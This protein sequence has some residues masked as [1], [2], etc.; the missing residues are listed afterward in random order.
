[1]FKYVV[2]WLRNKNIT[3]YFEDHPAARD[4]IVTSVQEV[5]PPKPLPTPAATP[6]NTDTPGEQAP[7]PLS[8][9]HIA[10]EEP[11][12]G[13]QAPAQLPSQHVVQKEELELVDPTDLHE[14]LPGD[15]HDQNSP[16]TQQELENGSQPSNYTSLEDAD[17]SEGKQATG[18]S[19]YSANLDVSAPGDHGDNFSDQDA[20]PSGESA[21]PSAPPS[22]Q[23]QSDTTRYQPRKRKN[24]FDGSRGSK[25]THFEAADSTEV[26]LGSRSRQCSGPFELRPGPDQDE[27]HDQQPETSNVTQDGRLAAATP[28]AAPQTVVIRSRRLS[29]EPPGGERSSIHPQTEGSVNYGITVQA[30][31]IFQS[32]L[33]S[34][35]LNLSRNFSFHTLSRSRIGRTKT[36]PG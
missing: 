15:T 2:H 21:G 34:Y 22:V 29:T 3:R 7:T 6:C 16:A 12:P 31:Y 11:D 33:S 32:S 14:N 26:E 36:F 1:V 17:D 27:R 28:P 35:L 8:P 18:D 19:Q 23:Y 20:R 9:Q 25:R 30:L 5:T 10:Q 13:D 4:A 24:Y